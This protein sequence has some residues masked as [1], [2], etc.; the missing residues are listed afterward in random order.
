MKKNFPL[1][2]NKGFTLIEL[3]VV[4]G[5]ISML[6]SLVSIKVN[7]ARA[8][9]R[10]VRRK[11]DLK[12]LATAMEMYY[13]EFGT[14]QVFGGGYA[15]K[16]PGDNICKD[17]CGA[18]WFGLENCPAIY[19]PLNPTCYITATSRV[20]YDLGYLGRPRVES[21]Y[22]G[23]KTVRHGSSNVPTQG[24]YG[25]MLYVCDGGQSYSLSA[26]LERPTQAEQ[27]TIC[28]SCQSRHHNSPFWGKNYA[29]GNKTYPPLPNCP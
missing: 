14:Y 3:M 15:Y 7:D 25:Y 26:Y 8:R 1:R 27:E 2:K 17:G 13:D 12:M 23:I 11:A 16:S 22:G 5:I 28:Q 24:S 6:A 19:N 18:G 20:L 10:D 9:V 29:I 4:V 21:P